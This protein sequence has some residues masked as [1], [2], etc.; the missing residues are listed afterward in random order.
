MEEKKEQKKLKLIKQSSTYKMIIPEDVELKIRYL[1]S[2][3]WD[4]E[5]SGV[6]FYTSTGSF[7]NN[8]LIITCK[9]IFLMDVGTVTTTE[10]NEDVEV[11]GYLGEHPECIDYKSGLIHSHNNM[12]TFFSTTDTDT[13]TER[14]NIINSFVSLIVNNVGEYTAAI[15]R[16]VNNIY[17][18][19]R[20][21]TYTFFENDNVPCN[22]SYTKEETKEIPTIEYFL[23]DIDIESNTKVSFPEI[24]NR[25]TEIKEE[26]EKKI[27]ASKLLLPDSI[28]SSNTKNKQS[29]PYINPYPLYGEDYNYGN[30]N[31]NDDYYNDHNGVKSDIDGVDDNYNSYLKEHKSIIDPDVIQDVLNK[32][33]SGNIFFNIDKTTKNEY[34]DDDY[35][36]KF[37]LPLYEEEFGG[38]T[39]AFKDW[40]SIIIDY[41]MINTVPYDSDEDM[42]SYVAS[43][44]V[45]TLLDFTKNEY[46]DEIIKQLKTYI[47]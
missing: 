34:I 29:K 45:D 36:Q 17:S 30:Y 18:I 10:F 4:R 13:L 12:A 21:G 25:L 31:D 40:M 19:K 33:L 46:I 2:K 32:I 35:M 37:L 9:D 42:V 14:G 7:E 24:S 28:N 43:E 11:A 44:L 27:Q 23:L 3:V 39:T 26:K 6:L 20:T 15:T 1:C 5:W 22:D 41:Y 47:D 16:K 38:N 8:D